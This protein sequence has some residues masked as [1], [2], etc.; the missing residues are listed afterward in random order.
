M[1]RPCIVRRP[2]LQATSFTKS[3]FRHS[4]FQPFCANEPKAP[5]PKA[6]GF[7][8]KGKKPK[9]PQSQSQATSKDDIPIESLD[10]YLTTLNPIL[11]SGE[12]DARTIAVMKSRSK[13]LIEAE[14]TRRYRQSHKLQ[15]RSHGLTEGSPK[16]VL[17]LEASALLVKH[18]PISVVEDDAANVKESEDIP[19][20]AREP[21]PDHTEVE[22]EVEELSS[23]GDGLA[24][25]ATHD[26]VFVVPFTIPGDRVL[27]K[28]Y[29]QAEH[30]LFYM[31]DFVKLLRPSPQREGV[32]PGCKYFGTCSGC[33]LQMLSY[34]DQLKHKKTIVEKAFAQFS[35]LDP[36]LIPPVLDT[37]GSPLQYE[38]RTKL[39]PHYPGSSPNK[40]HI[41]WGEPP[42]IGFCKKNSRAV[43]DIE[44][45][46]I[47][48]PIL[49]QGL[50][51]ER[52]KVQERTTQRRKGA[53]I[54]LRESTER[55]TTASKSALSGL[56]IEQALKNGNKEQG[57]SAAATTTEADNPA[58]SV[59]LAHLKPTS[60]E[61][62]FNLQGDPRMTYTYPTHV[63]IK[64]Y[65]SDNRGM[66]TEYVGEFSF[67]SNANSFFQNNNSIL[68]K[69]I[70][71]VRDNC[72][73]KD[74]DPQAPG[75]L[76]YLLDAYCGSG[77]FGVSLSPLFSSVLGIDVDSHSIQAAR[78]NAQSN[79]VP[80]AGFI[81]A[82]A[83]QLFAD[84]PFPPDQTMVVID[85]PRKGAS[86]D[87]LAQLC[88]FGPR[89][90]VYVSCNVHTQARDIGMLVHGFGTSWRYEIESL[91][92]FDFF[93]QTGHVEGLCFLDRVPDV[94]DV[95]DVPGDGNAAN[96][97]TE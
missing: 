39:T 91:R 2:C 57:D 26:I 7:P 67:R 59:E 15:K 85:P 89:R 87:F 58:A 32:T 79:G 36:A 73:P 93:P 51:V 48:T 44:Q 71:H 11:P 1:W 83:D 97:A 45:C 63:D 35:N 65:T 60:T 19:E 5:E 69:F 25:S 68:P 81:A 38:Y 78:L 20:E 92:G 43:M 70:K 22:L 80:N 30:P 64:T 55:M 50:K 9:E 86:E 66:S 77:L 33:Q 49:N 28:K 74:M 75:R 41:V 54:L 31:T 95:P 82:D 24:Y 47:A 46:P 21:L 13:R 42:P 12:Y 52:A 3:F 72:M 56:T 10:G 90:V 8:P 94:P 84:V 16:E 17:V 37:I 88:Q 27:A 6:G 61:L 34:E 40:E 96:P 23:T 53:T 18:K 4:T 29:P 76:K 14:M 62:S